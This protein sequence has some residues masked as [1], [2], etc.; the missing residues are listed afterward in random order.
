MILHI[1]LRQVEASMSSE[2]G[3][4]TLSKPGKKTLV[5]ESGTMKTRTL[6]KSIWRQIPRNQPLGDCSYDCFL[7]VTMTPQRKLAHVCRQLLGRANA[8]RARPITA[9]WGAN[10]EQYGAPREEEGSNELAYC[11]P[12][13]ETL[14]WSMPLLNYIVPFGIYRR[15][16]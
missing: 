14:C 6:A 9:L 2:K 11:A 5:I 12:A 15:E 16:I 8:A 3:T 13:M 7:F 1:Q 4:T 10:L